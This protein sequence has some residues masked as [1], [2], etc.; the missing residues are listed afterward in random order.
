MRMKYENAGDVL[1]AHLLEEIKKYAAG[2]LLYVPLEKERKAWGELS[3]YR[4]MLVKRNQL[5]VNMFL[6][7]VEVEQLSAKFHLSEETIKKI[8]YSRKNKYQLTYSPTLKSASEYS[9]AGLLEEW[10][11]TYLL[12]HRRN[13]IFSDGLRLC[14]RY[15][16]GPIMMPL[17]LFQRSSGPEYD[18]KWKVHP[19]VFEHRVSEW[20]NKIVKTEDTP[21]LLINYEHNKFEINSD[22]PL[23]EALVR[24][25]VAEYPV[26][27]WITAKE[28]HDAFL[29]TYGMYV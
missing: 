12:F 17:S 2:K 25:R 21:P 28:C 26:I 8:V 7:G 15:Y 18:M 5:I 20:L 19:E 4:H 29:N 13:E 3:G 1:P 10:I 27:I 14:Y 11:H 6:H 9:E 22:N 23:Y 24:S 16:I